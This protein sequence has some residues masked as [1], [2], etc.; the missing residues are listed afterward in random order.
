MD[1]SRYKILTSFFDEQGRKWPCNVGRK[2]ASVATEINPQRD[3]KGKVRDGYVWCFRSADAFT[4]SLKAMAMEILGE[5]RWL[6]ICM[7]G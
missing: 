3:G 5:E 6:R 4:G 2:R 7:V 1:D